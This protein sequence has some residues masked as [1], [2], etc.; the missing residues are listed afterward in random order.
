M[1]AKPD[2]LTSPLLLSEFDDILRRQGFLSLIADQKNL[3]IGVSG[4]PDSMALCWLLSQWLQKYQPKTK[5]HA[6]IVDHGLRPESAAESSQ[7]CKTIK[8]WPCVQ[9]H[10]LSLAGQKPKTRVMEAARHARYALMNKFAA[11]YVVMSIFLAHHQDDQAETFLF[12][13]AKGSGVDGLAGMR[14]AQIYDTVR[15][16]RPLLDIPK[17]RLLALCENEDLFYVQDPSNS[18]EKY[19]RPR[20]RQARVVLEREGLTSKRIAMTARRM[21]RAAEALDSTAKKTMPLLVLQRDTIQIVLKLLDLKAQPF[22]LV[23]RM[24]VL[25]LTDLKPSVIIRMENLE[26]LIEDLL[27]DSPFRKRTLGGFVFQANVKKDSFIISVESF[28]KCK[29]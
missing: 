22:D 21:A 19:A 1:V 11:K 10:I 6:L 15:F 27:L 16:L 17:S 20:L 28:Q 25:A 9:A 12:R 13:L 26:A 4:G 18:M 24:L 29:K 23:Y 5:L 7:V 3:A 2:C 14:H 8:A